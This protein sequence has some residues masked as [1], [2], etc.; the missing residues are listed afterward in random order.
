[1][2]G[3]ASACRAARLSEAADYDPAR[4][5]EQWGFAAEQFVDYKALV[6]DKSDN[7]P[8]VSGIGE[9]TATELLQKFGR[10]RRST[11]I[12]RMCRR[13]TA[14]NS[15]PGATAPILSR[16]LLSH[17]HR[18]PWLSTWSCLPGGPIAARG[19]GDA[20]QPLEFRSLLAPACPPRPAAPGVQMAMFAEPR[21]QLRAR[22]HP[23]H[24]VHERGGTRRTGRRH[25]ARPAPRIRRRDHLHRSDARRDWSGFAWPSRR[26]RATTSRCATQAGRTCPRP[27]SSRNGCA[28]RSATAGLPKTGHNMKYD[29]TMLQRAGVPVAPLRFDTH[30]GRVVVQPGLAQPRA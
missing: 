17:P 22:R 18:R 15:R 29:Y 13:A 14:P 23:W 28:A 24:M 19:S 20:V 4:F 25:C 27:R 21:Q 5:E 3:S 9:K 30:A 7:I 1:M 6:G 12:W 16:T 10:W 2:S 26:A 8:G 11:A